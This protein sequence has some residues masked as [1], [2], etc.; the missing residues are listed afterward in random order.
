MRKYFA[1]TLRKALWPTVI[2]F[3]IA[4]LQIIL[5]EALT[6]AYYS[7]GSPGIGYEYFYIDTPP[8]MSLVIFFLGASFGIPILQ[9]HFAKNT[10]LVDQYYSAPIKR[11]HLLLTN[12]LVGYLMLAALTIVI[13]LLL[14]LTVSSKP[15]VYV[16]KHF[17]VLIPFLLI[18]ELFLYS[19]NSFI[20]HQANSILDGIIYMVLSIVLVFMVWST[21][22]G[23]IPPFDFEDKPKLPT[24]LTIS[25]F[26]YLMEDTFLEFLIH[27]T[28]EITGR[29]DLTRLPTLKI[30]L[31]T[32][33]DLVYLLVLSGISVFFLLFMAKKEKVERARQISDSYVGYKVML[34]IFILTFTALIGNEPLAVLLIP[35]PLAII[36]TLI[37]RRNFKIPFR[38]LLPIIISYVAGVGLNFL[39][40]YLQTNVYGAVFI[41]YMS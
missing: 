5:P 38:H 13:V 19:I 25:P 1:Y 26:I 37:Y 30:E 6:E 34:P 11:K 2:I 41:S 16:M 32:I 27:P 36:L 24:F 3:V 21:I 15:N 40:D 22:L 14:I 28:S 10:R 39:I 29:P 31:G 7:A 18:A 17:F 8:I 20:F 23:L 12:W 4:L 9:F 35:L 33:L